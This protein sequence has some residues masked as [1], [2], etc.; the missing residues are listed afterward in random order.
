MRV[1][2]LLR[3]PVKSMGGEELSAVDLDDRGVTG[4]RAWA[5]WS[6]VDGQ[7]KMASG[8]HSRR[9]RRMDQVFSC[10]ARTTDEAVE[11]RLPDG[12]YHPAGGAGTDAALSAHFGES[13]RL[14]REASVSHMDAGS[15]SL[16]GTA[17]LYAAA[18]LAG[19]GKSP[20]DPRHFRANLVVAT[21][22]PWVEDS[23]VGRT[24][25]VGAVRLVV[26][27]RVVR[28]RM[29]DVAQVGVPEHGRIL[30]T[31]AAQR[32]LCCG[33]Y[34]DLVVT[35]TVRVGDKVTVGHG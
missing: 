17:S 2:Q 3:Y 30:K 34:A 29:V 20:L 1:A 21:E 12:S 8:K 7:A 5:V 35:G 14:Q 18:Q 22:E 32:E 23:W 13:V 19:E 27:E 28:C 25:A 9:F 6:E 16:I 10:A 24:V 4:D 33:V 11:I 26:T 15:V 31:L